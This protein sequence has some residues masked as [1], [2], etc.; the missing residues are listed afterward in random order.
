MNET[1]QTLDDSVCILMSSLKKLDLTEETLRKIREKYEK[2]KDID[3]D[4]E[5]YIDIEDVKEAD[6][7]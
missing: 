6:E 2:Y 1:E 4:D 3:D 5:I 7:G